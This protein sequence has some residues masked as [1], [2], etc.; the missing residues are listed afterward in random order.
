MNLS[1]EETTIIKM[2]R[3]YRKK[4]SSETV[5]YI[6]SDDRRVHTVIYKKEKGF[7]KKQ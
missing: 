3:Y 6:Y 7:Y 5:L 2:L 4:M 1:Q